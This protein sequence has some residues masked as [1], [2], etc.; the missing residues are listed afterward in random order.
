MPLLI[1]TSRLNKLIEDEKINPHQLAIAAKISSRSIYDY[2]NGVCIPVYSTFVQIANYF[3]VSTDYLLGIADESI[4][5]YYSEC[6]IKDIPKNFA[7]RLKGLLKEKGLKQI[8]LARMLHKQPLTI[9]E[10]V[11]AKSMPETATLIDLAKIFDCTTDY[12]LYREYK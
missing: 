3:E 10:W 4:R 6:E 9:S 1:F 11:N 2:I 7:A 12:L 5:C 8:D